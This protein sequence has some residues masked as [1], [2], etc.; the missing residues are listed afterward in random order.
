MSARYDEMLVFWGFGIML[1]TFE[2]SLILE[3]THRVK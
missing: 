1:N 3:N 2:K